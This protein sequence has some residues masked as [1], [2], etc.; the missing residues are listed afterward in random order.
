MP[1]TSQGSAYPDAD[2][3][4]RADDLDTALAEAAAQVR[5]L[6][7]LAAEQ[8]GR[9][10]MLPLADGSY[11]GVNAWTGR[12]DWLNQC[13]FAI[14]TPDGERLRKHHQLALPTF[15]VIIVAIAAFADSR[16][17][18]DVAVPFPICVI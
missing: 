2:S 14:R 6:E 10:Y 12:R 7:A 15:L 9:S 3:T 5:R 11:R 1:G 16:T 17:G 13:R 4:G 8:R 18:R